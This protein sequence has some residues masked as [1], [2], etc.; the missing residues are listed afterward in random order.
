MYLKSIMIQ[1]LT[2]YTCGR[3]LLSDWELLSREIIEGK[4]SAGK[5]KVL[6]SIL[7]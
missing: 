6:D 2:E 3:R 1:G 5:L 4:S 7:K